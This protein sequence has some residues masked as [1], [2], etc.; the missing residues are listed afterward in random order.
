MKTLGIVLMVGVFSVGLGGLTA[1][2]GQPPEKLEDKVR[3]EIREVHAQLQREK[4]ELKRADE[5]M[6]QLDRLAKR[7]TKEVFDDLTAHRVSYLDYELK[8]T[9]GALEK[10]R[11]KQAAREQALTGKVQTLTEKQEKLEQ[12][13]RDY[14]NIRRPETAEG[15]LPILMTEEERMLRDRIKE[16][17]N[18][19]AV[20]QDYLEKAVFWQRSYPGP[21]SADSV[22]VAKKRVEE[23]RADLKEA[24]AKLEAIRGRKPVPSAPQDQAA[25]RPEETRPK[26]PLTEAERKRWR[27]KGFTNV[28]I[29]TL[30]NGGVVV[31]KTGQT[32]FG[33]PPPRTK[34]K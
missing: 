26:G 1:A 34:R 22:V 21:E 20:E 16:L 11:Q 28:E 3:G 32:I 9:Q 18:E 12:E 15:G 31:D 4:E 14:V 10:E 24:E 7:S 29:D 6:E 33:W 13:L 30:Y 2:W 23:V 25:G 5:R 17:R 19:F 8:A 27:D